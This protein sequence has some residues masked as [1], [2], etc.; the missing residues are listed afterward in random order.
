MKKIL[1][2]IFAVILMVS[3]IVTS[4]A[5]C[6]S[7]GKTVMELDGTELSVNMLQLFLSRKKGMLCSAYY[8]GEDALA[9]SFWDTLMSATGETYNDHFTAEVTENVKTYLAA[10]HLF[11]QEGLE[12]PKSTVEEIDNEIARLIEDDADGSKTTFNTI[13]SPFGVNYKMLKEAYLLEA[14]IAYLNDYLFGTDGSKISPALVEDYYQSNYVRFKH[15][16]I[17]TY[18]L[19]YETD[20]DGN[21]IY[22]SLTNGKKI[23]YD[24]TKT[25]KKDEN[26]A[27]V[28]DKNGD[29]IYVDDEGK[30]AYDKKNGKRSPVLD[31]NGYQLTRKYTEKELI[32]ASDYAT[33]VIDKCE[34]GNYTLFDTMVENY[35]EDEG[36]EKYPNGYYLTR[37]SDY[38]SPEVLEALFE[39]KE[40][41]IRRVNSEYGIH[42]VMKYQLDEGGY[43]NK[44]NSDFFVNSETGNLVFMT[45]LKNMLLTERLK[46][47]LDKIVIDEKRI[48]G[49]DMKSVGANF[50]Y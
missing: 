14:K 5:G 25:P 8:F 1:A 36:M 28:L 19:V 22:Y 38:D 45:D 6:S 29:Q 12:L 4:F 47:Y 42:I 24:K 9:D 31:E 23:S 30:I 3:L 10:L 37:E 44:D 43:A 50:Y 20:A 49:I 15:V 26:G 13:L 16:F 17:Y 33:Q 21:D 2:R 41:E 39:M 35:S 32:A 7:R 11:E 40:G 34:E 46:P 18:A 27:A 48:A